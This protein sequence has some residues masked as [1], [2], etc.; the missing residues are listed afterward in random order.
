M[1]ADDMSHEVVYEDITN[2]IKHIAYYNQKEVEGWY[3]PNNTTVNHLKD[4]CFYK[5][6]S[7]DEIFGKLCSIESCLTAPRVIVR[8]EDGGGKRHTLEGL[9]FGTPSKLG[10]VLTDVVDIK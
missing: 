8:L 10:V 2:K 9:L 3:A 7:G 6:K 5:L 4:K 1:T